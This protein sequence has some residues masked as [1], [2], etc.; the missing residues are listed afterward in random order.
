MWGNLLEV[1]PRE[2]QGNPHHAR[3]K[4]NGREHMDGKCFGQIQKEDGIR[5]I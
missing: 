4:G 1:N 3:L 5:E 2:T